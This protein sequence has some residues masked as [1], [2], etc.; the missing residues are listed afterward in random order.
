MTSNE[1]LDINEQLI[2]MNEQM[3]KRILILEE[4]I[5]NINNRNENNHDG[6]PWITLFLSI[7]FPV[8]FLSI[9]GSL[10]IISNKKWNRIAGYL[11]FV[12]MILY[13]IKLFYN[14]WWL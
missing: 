3:V 1:L 13:L 8:W 11:N 14:P 6:I 9:I 4:D 7:I 5:R 12:L 2:E 10:W